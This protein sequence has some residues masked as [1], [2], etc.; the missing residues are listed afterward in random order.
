MI[1]RLIHN[2]VLEISIK[3]KLPLLLLLL[4]F[5]PGAFL[6]PY[7]IMLVFLGMPLLYMELILGQYLKKG[8]VQAMAAVCPLFKGTVRSLNIVS[9]F[10]SLWSNDQMCTQI[11]FPHC[12]LCTL[13]V[14]VAS[15][16]VSFIVSIYYNLIITWSLYYFFN[17]FQNPL[18]WDGCNKTWNTPNCT[19]FATNRTDSTTASQ[20]FFR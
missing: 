7:L 12:F 3:C 8:P 16:A 4:L 20:E 6:V 19:N 10:M 18:P 14:G 13:G 11:L 2:I 15:V 9:K 1:L 5:L 17:S